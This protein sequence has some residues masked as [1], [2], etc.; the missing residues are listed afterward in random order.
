MSYQDNTSYHTR[1]SSTPSNERNERDTSQGGW[2]TM[3]VPEWREN[4]HG[5]EG[6]WT[7]VRDIVPYNPHQANQNRGT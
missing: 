7:R 5:N 6:G 2:T 3:K 4:L 1:V